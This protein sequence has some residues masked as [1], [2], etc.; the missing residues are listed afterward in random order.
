MSGWAVASIAGGL[1]GLLIIVL[2]AVIAKAVKRTTE[3]AAA[4]VVALDEVRS[5]T[6]VLEQLEEQ[7]RHASDIVA[8][9]AAVLRESRP[10]QPEDGDGQ[11]RS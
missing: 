3:N 10:R 9:A 11:E 8:E 1:L 4:L 5:K 7:S 6:I 2:L